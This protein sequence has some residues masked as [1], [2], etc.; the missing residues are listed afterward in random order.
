M[1][2]KKSSSNKVIPPLKKGLLTKY[3][4]GLKK[5]KDERHKS[6]DKAVKGQ[7]KLEVMQHLNAIR[8]LQK[9]NEKNWRKLDN[10]MKYIQKKYFKEREGWKN[11]SATMKKRPSPKK[12]A[13]S[14]RKRTTTRKRASS[15]RKKSTTKRASTGRKKKTTRKKASTG[16]KRTTTKKASSGRKKTTKKA[17]TGRKRKTT[18]KK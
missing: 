1:V 13:S 2:K 11:S 10:D 8:T 15:G 12:K 5:N 18:R 17:G 16:R 9:S 14:G 7:D 6:L 3:G 4:Y